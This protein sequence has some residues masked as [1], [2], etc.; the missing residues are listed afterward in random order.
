MKTVPDRLWR[1]VRH[2]AGRIRRLPLSS[3]IGL[4][5]VGFVVL[6][7][8]FAPLLTTHSPTA[9]GLASPTHGPSGQYWF[10][11][12]R[13][14]RDIFSRLVAGTPR[15]LLVGFGSG[16]IALV[17][18]TLLGS[19]AATSGRVMDEVV[20]RVLDVIMAFPTIVLAA[21]LI[22]AFGNNNLLVVVLA[23]GFVSIPQMARI[24]RAN[25]SSQYSEDYVAAERVIGAPRWYILARHVARNCAAPVLVFT[26]ILV[27]GAIVFEASLSFIGAGIQGQDGPSS[28]GSVIS[29][30]EQLLASHGWWAT[31]FPGMLILLTVLSLNVLAEGITDAFAAPAKRAALAK[32]LV[33]EDPLAAPRSGSGEIVEL[34]GL[35]AVAARLAATARQVPAAPALLQVRDLR[36][37]FDDSHD[38][39][40]IVDGVSFEVRPGEVLGLVGESGCGKSITALTLLGMQPP[41][42]RVRGSI[43]FDGKELCG[44]AGRD[45]RALMGTQIAMVYQDA[46][47]ALNPSMTVG[48]QIGQLTRRG[49]TRT[50][51]QLV[52]LVG[53]DPSRTLRAYPHQLSGGQRQRVVIAM[54]L[55][56]SPKLIIAD[57][58]TT[59]LDVTVQAQV[60][61][62]LR[63]LQGELDFALIF[64]S[65]DLALVSDVC[66]RVAVM[67][68]GQIAE[69]GTVARVLANP[70]H[71]YT[72]GLLAAVLS[73][74]HGDERLSQIRGVV[75]S[76]SEFPAGC[77][78]ADRCPMATEVCWRSAPAQTVGPDGHVFACHHPA[79]IGASPEM[80]G[81]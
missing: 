11:V 58:P 19:L 24:V 40:D 8:I 51:E 43:L 72:R 65:H 78:F 63:R 7:G 50:P 44:M 28:W 48:A 70:A 15:S 75:P 25:V 18:G 33:A 81:R 27:A 53:L 68:G 55:S 56:R 79:A 66:D 34:P 76:P 62:L 61:E 10:G 60:I 39:V 37:G 29:Y 71:H 17:V 9:V 13:V 67:Y 2:A 38:G 12:D 47:S 16:G 41:A 46:L 6:V 57:E 59:A 74:E 1:G 69:A 49:G 54:A 4:G 36:I 80:A 45:R 26:T 22:I 23:I 5:F 30:G 73:L 42:A 21:V 32:A 35:G 20:M 77:R 64:V 52:E 14:G 31:F 3:R